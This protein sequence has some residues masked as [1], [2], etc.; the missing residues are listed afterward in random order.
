MH[1]TP[2]PSDDAGAL[3]RAGGP[4]GLRDE[5]PDHGV[6]KPAG[7]VGAHLDRVADAARP[8][9]DGVQNGSLDAAERNVEVVRVTGALVLRAASGRV[10]G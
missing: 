7:D 2:P 3:V 1:A 10:N 8:I 9:L 6:L 5:R 4:R